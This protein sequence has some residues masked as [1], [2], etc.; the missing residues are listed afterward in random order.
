MQ[1][2]SDLTIPWSLPRKLFFRFCTTYFL[3]YT[4]S[5]LGL[6]NFMWDTLVTWAGKWLIQPD[7][8][9]TVWPNGSGD[10]TYN[11]LVLFCMVLITVLITITWSLLDRKRKSYE[12]LSYWA[13]V[14][15][16]YGLALSMINYGMAKIGKT[17]FPFP[18]L[19]KL[20]T[21]FG[22]T[23]PMGLAWSYMG[24]STGYNLFTGLAEFIGG[25]FLFFRR[26]T[27]FAAL[28]SITVL[29]NVVAM[30]FFYD[31]PVKL[32]SI[33]LLLI[34]LY[35]ALPDMQRLLRFLFT[36]QAVAPAAH[37]Y[38]VFRTKWK[39][40]TFISLKYLCICALVGEPVYYCIANMRAH[41]NINKAPLYGIYTVGNVQTDS[42]G[43]LNER[44]TQFQLCQKIYIEQDNTFITKKSD[45]DLSYY[46]SKTDTVKRLLSYW[47]G[48]SDTV[49]LHY[50]QVGKDS[51]L[52]HG[53]IGKD[54]IHLRLKRK[55]PN[56]YLLI[57]RGFHWINEYPMNR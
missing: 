48:K 2:N 8:N 7:F 25:I 45:T 10:T 47:H 17:Q 39:R 26:T 24:Y 30:N 42:S 57:S 38:P 9:I 3:L 6:F 37:W 29:V 28:V 33:H 13:M 21:P 54:S 40:I 18:Y 53:V 49:Q 15:L 41:S 36:Q 44:I 5:S 23:S 1:H 46:R 14:I 51:I 55:D 20:E 50:Q 12:R 16:R 19:A 35:I 27:L 22:D 34:A 32:F 43:L 11:Y 52:L 31:I 4:L 56:D